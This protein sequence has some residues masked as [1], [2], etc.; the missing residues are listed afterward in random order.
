MKTITHVEDMWAPRFGSNLYTAVMSLHRLKLLSSCLR[1]DDKDTRVVWRAIHRL[2]PIKEIWDIFFENCQQYYS[3]SKNCMQYTI[4]FANNY[5]DFG[6][7]SEQEFIYVASQLNM[8][9]RS[10]TLII[11]KPLTCSMLSLTSAAL[12]LKV[13]KRYPAIM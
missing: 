11:H 5:S 2:A 12:L 8:T 4:R 6:D 1:F 9:G 13:L 7:V 10:L 3:P